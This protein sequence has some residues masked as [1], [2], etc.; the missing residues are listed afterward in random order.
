M[1]RP[2]NTGGL[3]HAADLDEQY[4]FGAYMAHPWWVISKPG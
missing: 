2:Y 4:A 1:G 3:I